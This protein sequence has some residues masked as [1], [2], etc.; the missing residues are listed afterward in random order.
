LDVTTTRLT[1]W[2]RSLLPPFPD[3][4][5]GAASSS[6]WVFIGQY[7][8][9]ATLYLLLLLLLSLAAALVE[10][11]LMR[12]IG[13]AVDQLGQSGSR[14]VPPAMVFI[15]VL[16]IAAA[17]AL[18]AASGVLSSYV[19]APN[20]EARS[21]WRAHE[22]LLSSRLAAFDEALPG[23]VAERVAETGASIRSL[24]VQAL[25]TLAF[26]ITYGLATFVLL[27]GMSGAFAPALLVWFALYAMLVR[28]FIPRAADAGARAAA[29]RSAMVGR[30]A[31]T[32]AGILAVKLFNSVGLERALA[33]G[34]VGERLERVFR[35]EALRTRYDIALALA[36]AALMI[37]IASIGL[38]QWQGGS[39]SLGETTAALALAF[40]LSTMAGWFLASVSGLAD[41]LGVIRDGIASVA[42]PREEADPPLFP[43]IRITRGD[44]DIRDVEVMRR[45]DGV[46]LGPFA[47]RIAPGEKVG[48]R[49]PSGC[50]KTTMVHALLRLQEVHAGRI[51]I[52][53]QD[54]ARHSI[55]SL[56]D[57]IAVA[58]QHVRLFHRSLRDNLTYGCPDA[59]AAA[60]GTALELCGLRSLLTARA[61]RAGI[62]DL[63]EDIGED[64]A[65]LS[66]GERQRVSLARA[67]LK[68]M[69]SRCPIVVLDEPTSSLD[70]DTA[71]TIMTELCALPWQPT[72]L[73]ISH[74]PDLLQRLDRVVDLIPRGPH[75][76]NA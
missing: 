60:L 62:H 5:E 57:Q 51:L 30:L 15:G 53:G 11:G 17:P 46:L 47:L 65:R 75:F 56:R 28:R 25:D 36:N 63:D 33:R 4:R 48:L 58:P 24:A 67:L 31:D 55:A 40:R 1:R 7:L 27:S 43:P 42:Q 2:L 69:V 68:A 49:G 54:I 37:A 39:L 71:G 44:I 70:P 9:P 20:L 52:D 72:L 59:P 45:A 6:I 18:R 74:Q 26:G 66:G 41:T 32:Y 10:A 64:G 76:T 38:A 22:A 29:A 13:A 61:G 12:A 34:H 19:L 3:E 50:G 35:N 16:L 23:R 8:R 73:V 14:H 21:I